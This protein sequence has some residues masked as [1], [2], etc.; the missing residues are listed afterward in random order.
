[1]HHDAVSNAA[2]QVFAVFCR[3]GQHVWSCVQSTGAGVATCAHRL[4]SLL[5]RHPSSRQSA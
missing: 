1:L 3:V 5:A 4:Q 2:S